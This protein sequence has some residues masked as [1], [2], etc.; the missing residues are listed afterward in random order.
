MIYY[1]D[2]TKTDSWAGGALRALGYNSDP[3]KLQTLIKKV[4]EE[5]TRLVLAV[6]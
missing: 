4:F 5:A 2:E 3:G 6:A 1:P